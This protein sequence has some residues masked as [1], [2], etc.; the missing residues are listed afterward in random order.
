[1]SEVPQI[2]RNPVY[3]M[4]LLVFVV[5]QLAVVMPHNFGML[6]AFRYLTG[7]IG[8]PA[9][10]T[11]GASMCDIWTPSRRSYGLGV[12]GVFAISAPVLGPLVGGFA[13]DAKGWTWP[14]WE[15]MWLSGFCC[16]LILFLLPET[17]ATNIL[18]RRARRVRKLTK[19]NALKSQSDVESEGLKVKVRTFR[20]PPLVLCLI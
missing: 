11:G 15:L 14:I 3:C 6:L 17:N 4:T 8:S 12:W 13:V 9:L 18:H 2:G 10:A 20:S 7:F 16:V 19:N 5:L 1:M